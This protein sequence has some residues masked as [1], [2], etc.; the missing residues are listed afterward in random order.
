MRYDSQ[1]AQAHVTRR[2]SKPPRA[3]L[4]ALHVEHVI[5][6]DARE[7]IAARSRLKAA[8]LLTSAHMLAELC[9]MQRTAWLS[10][11]RERCRLVLAGCGSR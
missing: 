7:E 3:S 8:L 1:S 11:R 10:Q 6:E 4:P 9:R 2:N 5:V